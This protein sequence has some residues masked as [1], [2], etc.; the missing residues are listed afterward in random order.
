MLTL[1]IVIPAYNEEG[2]IRKCLDAISR[3]TVQPNEVIVVDNN[4]TDATIN[5]ARQYDFVRV[6]KEQKQG[7]VFARNSGFNAAKTDI[8]ARID[9]DS[10]LEEN[11]IETVLNYFTN[12]AL[13]DAITGNCYFYD[14]P[15]RVVTQNI[16]HFAYY[17]VQ[18]AVTGGEILWGSNMAIT[19]ESWRAVREDCLLTTDVHEDMDL[20]IHLV[21]NGYSIARLPELV[22]GVSMRRGDL[23]LKSVIKYLKPW[24]KTYWIN[25]KYGAAA[26]IGIVFVAIIIGTAP[27]LLAR[28]YYLSLTPNLPV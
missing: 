16:H 22:A 3:Q 11:W 9:S 27:F 2:Y 20:T 25:K 5:I 13:S 28:T 1:T 21:D 17:S 4:S 18:K 19:R 8:I 26:V 6:I 24:P 12:S 14:F 10:Q 15:V 7:I 23:S